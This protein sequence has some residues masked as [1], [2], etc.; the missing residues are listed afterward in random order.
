MVQFVESLRYKPES[1]G[2]DSRLHQCNFSWTSSFRP[3]YGP[4]VDP[5]SNT[6]SYQANVLGVKAAGA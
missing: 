1:R 6:N 3:Y 2:F 5:V 4:E